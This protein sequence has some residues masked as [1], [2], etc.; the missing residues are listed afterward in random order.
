MDGRKPRQCKERYVNYLIPGCFKG[1][2]T[3]DEDDLLVKLY[4]ENGPK[5]SIIKKHFDNILIK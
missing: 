2:W 4:K 1:Q 3:N 5:W